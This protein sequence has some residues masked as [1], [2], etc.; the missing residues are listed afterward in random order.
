MYTAVI[1]SSSEKYLEFALLACSKF[2]FE[3][4]FPQQKYQ[5]FGLHRFGR[6]GGSGWGKGGGGGI[7]KYYSY[8]TMLTHIIIDTTDVIWLSLC[9]LKLFVNESNYLFRHTLP[10]PHHPYFFEHS[11]T[12]HKPNSK[13]GMKKMQL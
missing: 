5:I 2:N 1:F 11:P 12:A 7:G 10:S 6:V 8:V 3:I 13:I 9:L 4:S